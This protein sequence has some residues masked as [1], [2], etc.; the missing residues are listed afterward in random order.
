[1]IKILKNEIIR[2]LPAIIFFLVF[3]NLIAFTEN[4]MMRSNRSVYFSYGVATVGA[5]VVGKFLL[6]VNSLPYINLFPN[7][8]LIY[9]ISWKFLIYGLLAL[10]FRILEKLVELT[11]KF[12]NTSIIY[13][14][15]KT[16][17]ASPIFWAIQIWV[18]M[19]FTAYIVACELIEALGK[20]DVEVILFGNRNRKR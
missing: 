3:F 16:M 1:M 8:P 2:F 20:K 12:E 13:A 18:L 15:L 14:H 4:L 6:I 19:L 5:L 7:K 11:F 10:L 17:L 9:N